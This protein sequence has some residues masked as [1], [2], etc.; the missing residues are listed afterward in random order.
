LP[1]HTAENGKATPPVLR[2]ERDGMSRVDRGEHVRMAQDAAETEH[3][4]HHE[5]E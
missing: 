4:D 2:Q 5:P 1:G 3:R